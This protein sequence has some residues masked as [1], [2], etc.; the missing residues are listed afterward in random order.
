MVEG[1]DRMLCCLRGGRMGRAKWGMW[2]GVR[3][4]HGAM[5]GDRGMMTGV[6]KE[7]GAERRNEHICCSEEV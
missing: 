4:R 3:H 7:D 5:L 1:K 6:G 2:E